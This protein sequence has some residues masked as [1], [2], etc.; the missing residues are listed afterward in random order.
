MSINNVDSETK[1]K[2]YGFAK[3]IEGKPFVETDEKGYKFVRI[4]ENRQP[5]MC[6]TK[7]C[8]V[9][10]ATPHDGNRQRIDF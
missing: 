8:K 4:Y 10:L 3:L 9:L 2:M 1:F 6:A 5:T 7:H